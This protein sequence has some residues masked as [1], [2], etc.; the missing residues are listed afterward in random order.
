MQHTKLAPIIQGEPQQ[1]DNILNVT[2]KVTDEFEKKQRQE[3]DQI[4][5]R[6]AKHLQVART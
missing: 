5:H 1:D 2:S 6:S 3:K 4:E